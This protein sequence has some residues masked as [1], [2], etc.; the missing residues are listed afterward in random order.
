M[1]GNATPQNI[2]IS[3]IVVPGYKYNM[4]DV[5]ASLGLHQL[6][7]QER[8]IQRREEIARMYDAAF[9]Q[10]GDLVKMQSRPCDA[11]NR[12]ALHLYVLLLELGELKVDR[13]QVINALLAENIGASMH[14]MPL[15]MQPFYQDKYGYRPDDLP[16]ARRIGE[17]VLSLPLVPQMT[18]SD[19]EDVIAAVKKILTAYVRNRIV[20]RRTRG[21]LCRGQVKMQDA[22]VWNP[23]ETLLKAPK[24]TIRPTRGWVALQCG[25][26]GR[27]ELLYL[28][29]WRD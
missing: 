18:D 9:L 28:L 1:R 10:F 2:F 11:D 17:S 12:H 22:P 6:R 25:T 19:V 27:G 29:V 20:V 23:N 21:T 7:K 5:Q 24:V 8:F 13:N 15:H 14:F 4:T 16:V 3:Q 26:C